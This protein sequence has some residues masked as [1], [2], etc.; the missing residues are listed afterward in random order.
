MKLSRSEDV[1]E[2]V[3]TGKGTCNCTREARNIT[4]KQHGG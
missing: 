2:R 1:E 4:C 3:E